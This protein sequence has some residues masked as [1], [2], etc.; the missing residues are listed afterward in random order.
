MDQLLADL[1]HTLSET[2]I[3]PFEVKGSI[4]LR[5]GEKLRLVSALS[6]SEGAVEPCREIRL[7][8]CLCGLAAA[9]GEMVISC[10][11]LADERHTRCMPGAGAHGHLVI[12]LK[13]ASTVVGV[14][15]LFTSPGTE[16]NEQQLD[17]FSAIGSQV[18]I[19]INNARLYEET[20]SS[21]LHDPLT[22]LANR[23]FMEIQL[24]KCFDAAQRY[25]E[26][27]SIIMV[28]IDHF[29]AY[30]DSHGHPEGDRLLARVAATLVREARIAD[31]VFRYGGEEFLLLL[32]WTDAAAAWAMAERVR[33]TVEGEMGVTISV[34]VVSCQQGM[35]DKENLIRLADE[36][37]YRAKQNGRNRVEAGG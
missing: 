20:R 5:D 4:F 9:K 25:G 2:G 8:E 22:G 23:R 30:N 11:S 37:L 16:V 17:L 34:G 36:A 7:G 35:M 6:L 13:A 14:L 21:A 28:D 15:N 31:Y 19:A 12:P 33:M 24:G 10:D 26:M 1:L 32:P 29:K 18:G 3:L 27:I